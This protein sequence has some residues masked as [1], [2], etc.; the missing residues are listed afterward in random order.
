MISR[1]WGIELWD[2]FDNVT[3][4][5]EKSI[6]FCEKYEAFLKDRCTV[7]D[8]Y[9]KALKK[10]TKTYTPKHKEQEEF[11]NK[12]SYTLAFCSTLRELQDIASQHEIIA[13]NLRE[14]AIKQI[15]IT[16]KECREQRKKC[17]DE[18]SKIKRQLD[19][20]HDLMIKSLRKYEECHDSA[21]RAKECYEKAHE[22][23]DLSR[24]QLEKTRDL[25]TVKSKISDDAHTNYS[26]QVSAY[27][28]TQRS[29]YERQLPSILC[30]LQQLDDKRS[31]ELKKVYSNFVQSH[32]E[33][34]PRVQ[35]CLD[36]MSKQIE[37]LNPA[38]DAQV[39][40]D[41]YQT[42]YAIPDDQKPIDL[43]AGDPLSSSLPL[44]NGHE[45]SIYKEF[46][47]SNTLRSTNSDYMSQNGIATIYAPSSHINGTQTLAAGTPAIP[48]RKTSGAANT[49]R[50][51][52]GSSTQ[53]KASNASNI[54]AMT[55]NAPFG[56]LPP[57]QRV[58]K[59]QEQI[60][61]CKNE[62]EK[63]QKAKEGLVKMKFV[64]QEN[65]KFGDEQ[66]VAQQI[67]SMDE[68][69][70]KLL[71]EIKRFEAYILEIERTRIPTSSDI[72]LSSRSRTSYDSDQSISNQNLDTASQNRSSSDIPEQIGNGIYDQ[73][74]EF[75]CLPSI[76]SMTVH[77]IDTPT[78][79]SNGSFEDEDADQDQI[80]N[81]D[82]EQ[83]NQENYIKAYALY[84]FNGQGSN[85]C[86]YVN[87]ASI[88]VGECVDILEDDHG[89][90]WTRIQ[91]SDGSS[92]FV[93]SSYLPSIPVVKYEVTTKP[94]YN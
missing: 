14:R 51:L 48:S 80:D 77:Q 91:K 15:Q 92:G 65:P 55:I 54:S 30:D 3:K 72:D 71:A 76:T 28:D 19:K 13:D 37:Q 32:M 73:T 4:Y 49:I 52:F 12:Y 9:A 62:L 2:Q 68:N 70:E 74:N 20:Q 64:F 86:Q 85:G 58:R 23:L 93:P 39:V 46:T 67:V 38:A 29:F 88:S 60:L 36:E 89:D 61:N 42:G 22:D 16:I 90:G 75:H 33:V 45:Q 27:N 56:G 79:E 66:D 7:E 41:E 47:R 17:L 94:A 10:L 6:Q 82:F 5:T 69:I 84:D 1:S 8:D 83:T 63:K 81:Q 50:K 21:R 25:M 78:R 87:A 43:N 40:I 35:R 53:R 11:H 59:F 44:Y 34:L 31:N 18:Y 24:A 26:T 57:A